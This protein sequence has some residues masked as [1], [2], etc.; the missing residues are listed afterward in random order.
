[1]HSDIKQN[2]NNSLCQNLFDKGYFH[3]TQNYFLDPADYLYEQILR[4]GYM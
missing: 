3:I 2:R 4:V 1:M